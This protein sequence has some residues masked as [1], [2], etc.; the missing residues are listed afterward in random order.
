MPAPL[1]LINLQHTLCSRQKKP[2]LIRYRRSMS[3]KRGAVV[4]AYVD[5]KSVSVWVVVV[6]HNTSAIKG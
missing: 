6:F 4:V 3:V 5:S 1:R 2:V